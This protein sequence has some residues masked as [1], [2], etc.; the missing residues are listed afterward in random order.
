MA[1][2]AARSSPVPLF[3]S[4]AFSSRAAS[5]PVSATFLRNVRRPTP[6]SFFMGIS[7]L[8]PLRAELEPHVCLRY[9]FR[10]RIRWE[11]RHKDLGGRNACRVGGNCGSVLSEIRRVA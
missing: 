2:F 11:Q 4:V 7:I 10:S 6:F 3:C 8:F 1:D 5:P 9:C